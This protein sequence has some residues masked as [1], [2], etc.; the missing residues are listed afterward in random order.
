MNK[1]FVRNKDIDYNKVSKDL[2]ISPIVSKILIN[3]EISSKDSINMFLLGGLENLHSPD[4][5]NDIEKAGNIIKTNISQSK[6]IR[7]VGDYDVDGVMS[8]YVLFTSLLK[9][10]AHVDYVVPD[11]V[12]DGYGINSDIVNKAKK[13]NI[14]LII[15]CDNGISAFDAVERANELNIEIIITDHHDLSYI[16]EDDKKTYIVPEAMAVI[17]PKN[18]KCNYP[19]KK[20]CGAGVAYKLIEYV[21]SLYGIEKEELY[22]LLE[23]VALATV[24]DV[25]DLIDE[26]RIMVKHGL[27][28]INNTNN[29]GLRALIEV[30][31]IKNDI[32]TYHL[33]FI[34]GPT[35]NASGRLETALLAID[36]LLSEDKKKATEIAENLRE[37]NE[38][39]KSITNIGIENIKSQIKDTELNKDK[40]LIVF[41]PNI[42]E[43]VAGIIAG[44]IKEMY[45]KPTIVLTKSLTGVKGSARSIEEY[46]IF[47]ELNACKELLIGFGG[48]PMAAGLSLD[49]ADIDKL[50]IKLNAI[51]DLSEEDFYKKIYIDMV[52]PIES[53]NDSLMKDLN[54][55]EPFGKGNSKPLFGDKHLK[56]KKLFKYGAKE[57]VLKFNL[58]DNKGTYIDGLIFNDT[59]SFEDAIVSKYG[60]ETLDKLYRGQENNVSLDIIYYPSYNDY[61][62]KRTIQITIESFRI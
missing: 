53:L 6:N 42:H 32:G 10:G 3:R 18:P 22:P 50:R 23:Y 54:L 2:G 59:I 7:I 27:K 25:V 38:E 1:W 41:E 36:L 61:N 14:D 11:R 4:S 8:V 51:T 52:L 39:R 56:I 60:K 58:Y 15:T 33:G 20:L 21:Y 46:N 43:S 19:F 17:N 48:H 24:C 40:V 5:M 13:D 9:L 26:N 37:L 44:R 31:A 47:E 30:S 16:L 55:L 62:G 12:Q 45:N 29:I 57:N 35:I 28:L 34:I 49:I